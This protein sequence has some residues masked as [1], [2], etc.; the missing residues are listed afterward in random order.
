M[1]NNKIFIIPLYIFICVSIAS[2]GKTNDLQSE[3][4]EQFVAVESARAI[5]EACQKLLDKGYEKDFYK[6]VSG[7]GS[8]VPHGSLQGAYSIQSNGKVIGYIQVVNAKVVLSFSDPA[9]VK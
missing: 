5:S 6:R 4:D 8:V 3:K 1:R 9:E 7:L 2:C